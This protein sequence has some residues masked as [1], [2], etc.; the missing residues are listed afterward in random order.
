MRLH[1]FYITD[2]IEEKSVII[3]NRD[4]I[5]QWRKVFRYNVGSQVIVFNGSGVDCRSTIMKMSAS[6]AELSVLETKETPPSGKNMWLCLSLIKK[7]NFELVVQKAVEL[8]VNNIVPI[9]SERSEKK[10]INTERLEKIILEATEQSGRGELLKVHPL[11]TQSELLESEVLPQEKIFFHPGY[12]PIQEYLSSNNTQYS[13]AYF[14]GPEG[15]FSEEEIA[16]FKTYNVSGFSLGPLILRAETA[17]IAAS[18]LFL[19]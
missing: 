11:M 1:R 15:G 8:G 19:L 12:P 16:L 5:H 18:A 17:A 2:T 14:V 13:Y 7:D 10:K 9:I 4:L 3:T 6:E